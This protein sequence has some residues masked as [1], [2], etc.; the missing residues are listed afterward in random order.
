MAAPMF[1]FGGNTGVSSP[2]ELKRLRAVAEALSGPS[3]AP[4]DVGEGL[5]AIGQALLYR[6]TTRKADAMEK[7][8]MAGASKKVAEALFGGVTPSMGAGN[9][10]NVGAALMGQPEAAAELAASSPAPDVSKNGSTFSP[11]ISTVQSGIKN[12]D[13]STI[14]ITNPYGLAAVAATGKAE[15]GW[16]AGNAAR[17]WSDPSES[18][19][20]GTAGG[21]MSWRA[22]RLQGLRNYAASKGEQGN[23]SPETQAEF[24]LRE[25]PRLVTGLNGAKSVEEAQQLMNSSWK[26]AGYDRPG[27]EASRRL[28]YANAYA[29][30]FQGSQAGT[31][32]AS[33]D[34]SAGMSAAAAIER[35]APASGYVDPMVS[36]PNAQPSQVAALP[37]QQGGAQLPPL[38]S[39][40]VGAA[41]Q[42]AAVPQQR[43]Q[44]PVQV[45][46]AQ[47]PDLQR[48]YQAAMDPWVS[49]EQR[50]LIINE[51]NRRQQESD[52]VRQMQIRK[53][54]LEIEAA[55]AGQWARLDDGRLYNQRTGEVKNAPANANAAPSDL[56]LN[57]QYGTDANGNPV[58]LQLGKNGQVV[59][60]KMPEGVTLSK[61]PIKLDAGTHFVLLD[62]ITRQPV[63][64]IPKENYREAYDTEAGK[65]G[66]KSQ[67]EAQAGAPQ[68]IADADYSIAL[69]DEMLTHPGRATATGMTSI[70][71]PRNYLAGTDATDFN[72]RSKQLEGRAF[73]QAFNSLRGGGQITEVEGKKATE[74]IARLNRSQ[75]DEEYVKALT[76]LKGILEV[77]KDRARQKAAGGPTMSPGNPAAPA[78]ALPA[79][80]APA[81][82]D[83]LG[84]R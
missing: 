67:A 5:N 36:A 84:L 33:L 30:Q 49:D 75:S 35:Q 40:E 59:Q 15:S 62:P 70:I 9:G 74:A 38:P 73:L 18:G 20:A 71:D 8:G 32:V 31:E 63:G 11:F 58:L 69:I 46:Q 82:A 26:F 55:E 42:V 12:E 19:Q 50:A 17:S 1:I 39:R 4:R 48:L 64:Q 44:S 60:S 78:S 47:G 61:E 72:T 13:G 2:K 79:P 54:Q 43:P 51:I 27:G 28:S 53:G 23:G 77:G 57:P 66:G 56:G 14:A 22:E 29:P 16:D 41:P 3:R 68:V 21:V 6:S 45:A 37:P 52:P 24:F 65:A 34:P 80:A 81:A 10:S 83:P 7:E 25:D 76:E